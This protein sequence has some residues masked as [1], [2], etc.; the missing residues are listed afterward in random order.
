MIEA[1]KK[2]NKE[3]LHWIVA[4]AEKIPIPDN[5]FERATIAFG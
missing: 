1:G 4:S 5:S 2:Q 3:K